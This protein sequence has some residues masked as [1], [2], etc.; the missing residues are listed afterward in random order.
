MNDDQVSRN[1]LLN[2]TNGKYLTE[3]AFRGGFDALQ[4]PVKSSLKT[5]QT[6]GEEVKGGNGFLLL[7]GPHCVIGQ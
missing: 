2:P 4:K 5:G 3:L 7:E 1:E 6:E